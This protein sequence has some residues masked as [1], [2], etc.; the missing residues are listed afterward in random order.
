MAKSKFWTINRQ[1]SLF[2]KAPKRMMVNTVEPFRTGS[3]L[4]SGQHRYYF[5]GRH[6]SRT[7]GKDVIFRI[8]RDLRFSEDKKPYKVSSEVARSEAVD[9]CD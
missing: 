9:R 5:A 3:H 7:T 6:H 8:H 1:R 4:S 2:A